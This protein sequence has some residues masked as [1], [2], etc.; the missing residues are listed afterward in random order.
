MRVLKPETLAFLSKIF[1][2]ERGAVL[3]STILV[4]F[5]FDESLPNRIYSEDVLW[6]TAQSCL[7]PGEALDWSF[8]KPEA[9]YLVY[10]SCHL[11]TPAS[12]AEVQ[13][14]VAE[15]TK[16]LEVWG[17]RAWLGT[18]PSDPEPFSSM[19]LTWEKAYGGPHYPENP[20]GMGHDTEGNI[21]YALPHIQPVGKAFR[22]VAQSWAQDGFRALSPGW[23]QRTRFFGPFDQEWLLH[24]WPYYPHGSSMQYCMTA[25]ED[26]WMGR[27]FDGDERFALSNMH[28][29][30]P[31]IESSFPEIRV[32]LFLNRVIEDKE[33]FSERPCKADTLWLF[34][35]HEMGIVAYRNLTLVHDEEVSDV[36]HVFVAIESLSESAKPV[37]HY[38]ETLNDIIAPP[39]EEPKPAPASPRPTPPPSSPPEDTTSPLM[40]IKDAVAK[41][42]A[43]VKAALQRIGVSEAD[44]QAQMREFEKQQP[45]TSFDELVKAYTPEQEIDPK[46]ALRNLE[47]QADKVTKQV[48]DFF[49]KFGIRP[50]EVEQ[51]ALERSTATQS[52]ME[53]L[54]SQ[55][56]AHP[57]MSAEAKAKFKEAQQTLNEA[58]SLSAKLSMDVPEAADEK[59]TEQ[60]EGSGVIEE[61]ASMTVEQVL[62]MH[63]KGQTL[64]GYDLRG[65]DFSGLDLSGA[66]FSGCRLE[67]SRF[68][69][70]TLVGA[71]FTEARL[72]EAHF[73]EAHAESAQFTSCLA[74]KTVFSGAVLTGAD[75]STSDLTGADFS[76]ASMPGASLDGAIV[77]EANFTQV[78]ARNI[79]GKKAD[80]SRTHCEATNFSNAILDDADLTGCNCAAADF[81]YVQAERLRL[82]EAICSGASFADAVLPNLRAGQGTDFSSADFRRANL[83]MASIAGTTMSRANLKRAVLYRADCSKTDMTAARL[84][85]ADARYARFNQADFTEA[86]LTKIN[87]L[88]ASF[89]KARFTLC[90][91]V[92]ANLYGADVYKCVLD[93]TVLDG[94]NVNKTFFKPQFLHDAER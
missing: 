23:P 56:M 26:Q 52:N 66:D 13:V 47:K 32:R 29:E 79:S 84:R 86:D 85:K 69:K 38:Q 6:P 57:A 7:N 15:K 60:A 50:E 41:L 70:A 55:L 62:A 37:A 43:D 11:Q 35:D 30:K 53:E 28:A 90:R 4:A 80:F 59:V 14:K 67:K 1:D 76:S 46:V 63:A 25:P 31:L 27:F 17:K 44:V 91:L 77:S 42:E 51:F 10:G 65:L 75:I 9:E 39:K 83:T 8:P 71:N 36:R 73:E 87:G 78:D 61:A 3:S 16:T 89:R 18:R 33:S 92:K 24:R 2:S 54:F 22:P 72:D 19:P 48:E 40:G 94:A 5:A 88:K 21:G 12:A 49:T 93:Q 20:V 81:R 45:L 82:Y 74:A 34:P 64:H 58:K 68:T